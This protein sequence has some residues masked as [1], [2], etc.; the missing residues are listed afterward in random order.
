MTD[1][2]INQCSMRPDESGPLE[3]SGHV[4]GG[5]EVAC[6][7]EGALPVAKFTRELTEL[8]E[9]G[10]VVATRSGRVLHASSGACELVGG[11]AEGFDAAWS[12]CWEAV[13]RALEAPSGLSATSDSAASCGGPVFETS[14]ERSGRW[15]KLELYDVD[16]EEI[17]GEQAAYV[18]LVL[19][20]S[21]VMSLAGRL[22][23]GRRAI[24]TVKR[25]GV[26]L[27]ASKSALAG[28]GVAASNLA[29]ELGSARALSRAERARLAQDAQRIAD[30]AFRSGTRIAE[31][32]ATV[33]GSSAGRSLAHILHDVLKRQRPH[34]ERAGVRLEL[35]T[36]ASGA[37]S[38]ARGEAVGEALFH[39]V[40][41]AIEASDHESVVVVECVRTTTR[42]ILFRVLDR[43]SG[44]DDAHLDRLRRVGFSTKGTGR[45]FGL[46]TARL[47]ARVAHGRVRIARRRSGGTVAE[48]CLEHIADA[49]E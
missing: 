4:S 31:G 14:I 20:R 24:A 32:A 16:E 13:S 43:G 1:L 44:V 47:A 40:D 25:Q 11:A 12:D 17:G 45:G 29:E 39:V 46:F 8:L 48:I 6:A 15:L 19:D 34:A 2:N 38:A 42:A 10:F 33:A 27:H 49:E 18:A 22:R 7:D 3:E 30:E 21:A 36:V 35:G 9:S 26:A 23:R 5:P 28:L 37:L 41:N